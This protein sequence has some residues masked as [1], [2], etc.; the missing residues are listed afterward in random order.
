[1]NVVVGDIGSRNVFDIATALRDDIKTSDE[2]LT[3][4]FIRNKD[5][6]FLQFL[7]K[8]LSEMYK[9]RSDQITGQPAVDEITLAKRLVFNINKKI[10]TDAK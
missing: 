1:M 10:T 8:N 9:F 2:I 6:E 7:V 3:Q 4:E 5:K